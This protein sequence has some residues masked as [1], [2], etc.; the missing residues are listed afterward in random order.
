MEATMNSALQNLIMKQESNSK[1]KSRQKKYFT[2]DQI[3]SPI[4]ENT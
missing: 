4:S 1:A 3:A 2:K